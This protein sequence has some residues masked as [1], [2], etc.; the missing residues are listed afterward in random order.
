MHPDVEKLVEAGKIP[1]PVGE[2]L[3]QLAPGNF[4]LHKSFG[5]GKIIG[6]DF[7]AKKV[8]VDFENSQGQEMDLQ[9]A[10]QKTE[11]VPEDDFRAVKI[12]QIETLRK[13]AKEDAVALVVHILES[14]GGSITGEAIEELVK[15]AV[16]PDKEYKKWWDSTKKAVKESRKAVVPTKRTEAIVL[17]DTN[18]T[19][20]QALVADF[21]ASKDIKG[22][23]KALESIAG[24]IGAFDNDIDALKQ[25]LRD[26]DEGAKKAA[27]VQLGQAMQL[28]AARDE[29]IDSNKALELD[30]SSVRLSDLI[31]GS[32][33]EKIAEELVALPSTRQRAVYEA[34]KTAFGDEWV[35]K[36]V[37][38]FNQVGA[39]G[40]TEIAR[41]LSESDGMPVL[42]KHLGSALAR[43]ALGPD[44]LIWVC[45]ERNGA[46]EA[47][48]GADVGAS[49]LNLLENDHLSDGPRKTSRLQTLVNDDKALL[50]DLVKNM[51]LN[52]AKNF[53]RR[54]LDCPVFADLE[55][56]SLMARIIKVRPETV[57]LV[58]GEN[59][60]KREEPLLV[61]WESLEKKKN[62]L[63]ELLREKIPQNREDIK[64]AK[65]Y[66][67]L[68]ENF[69]YKSAKDLEKFLNHRRAA[70]ELEISLARGTDFKG[71][72]TATVNIGTIV[73]LTDTSGTE[74]TITVLGAWD[75]N[76][77]K[78]EVSYL[79]DVGKA[80][81]GLSVSDDAK[82]R[83]TQTEKMETL[84]I[85]SISAYHP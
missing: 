42:I 49:I 38:V 27:R 33:L 16:I 69:E 20:A 56:K 26:I 85:K 63:Q 59:A 10:M 7:G 84:T 77:E 45:R 50:S 39:R 2:R 82:I 4:C 74:Q 28:V 32:D 25:L 36:I 21:E 35:D 75:S 60:A 72:D 83:D 54:L 70:L 19:P 9:F 5:A 37:T 13:L 31:A 6:W 80:L 14:H 55:K 65:S 57:E 12:A 34:F 61:S 62:E 43:R 48:F 3:S 24:D 76:P 46:A 58:S 73:N 52:E 66:G 22:M 51:D 18:I 53:A 17:R 30:A 64:I 41:I 29:V 8:T 71:A 15:G 40:V 11:W 44:A 81:M 1:A 78:K 79:S 23:I 47:V 67:D 68:R